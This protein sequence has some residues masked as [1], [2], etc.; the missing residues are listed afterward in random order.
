M[1]RQ[2][3][4]FVRFVATFVGF[5]ARTIVGSSGWWAVVVAAAGRIAEP[6]RRES[7]VRYESGM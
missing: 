3:V 1:S 6:W 7:V 2:T 5:E 4:D